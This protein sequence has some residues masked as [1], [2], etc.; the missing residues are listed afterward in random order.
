M[1]SYLQAI[2]GLGLFLL[3]MITMTDAL[4][5]LAGNSIRNVL[6]RFTRS[7]Y[8]GALTGAA[9]TALLQSSSATTVAAV[10]FVGA[11]LMSFSSALGIIFG[12]NLGTTI[13]GWVVALLGFKLNLGSVVLPLILLGAI[14]RLCF[15]GKAR[16]VGMA[17][18]GFGLIFVGIE[19]MQDGMSG[20][21]D[22]LNILNLPTDTWWGRL[23]LL[24]L[25]VVFT[26]ITQSSSAGVAATLT[27]LATDSI[28][29]SQGLAL[30]I[31]MDIG[32]TVTA[33]MATLG[34][35]VG[36]RRT[37]F[38]HL[39]YNLLT[40]V[41]AF[42]LL[43]GYVKFCETF[44]SEQL[45]RNPEFV[46]VAF[47]SGFNLLGVSLIL[48]FTAQFTRLMERIIP[49]I[50]S[51]YVSSLDNSLLKE[52]AMAVNAAR[53]SLVGEF[54]ALLLNCRSLLINGQPLKGI[55]LAELQ[56]AL[57]ESHHYVDS[58]P[59]ES[60]GK[61]QAGLMNLLHSLDHLQRFHER[62]D[63]DQARADHA[64]TEHLLAD[65]RERMIA[66]VE[67]ILQRIT[68]GNW[69]DAANTA[70]TTSQRMESTTDSYRN[71][72]I[73]RIASGD[74]D[75]PEATASLEAFR[76]MRRVSFHIAEITKRLAKV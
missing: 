13:T 3:G 8:S 56:V 58:I 41:L 33:V 49:D 66:D 16:S 37:G 35:S 65:E 7:P 75:V 1:I 21:R 24:L 59:L 36:S 73:A 54:N 64:R 15:G 40:G 17:M 69:D 25:G 52:P 45:S 19:Q 39:I 44:F 26:I 74:I 14:L 23:Q 68:L 43:T 18:A 57:D 47:H 67:E 50:Q 60:G 61:E 5:S 34:G 72:I 42:L 76:W 20:A 30:V 12:A 53:Q 63:E 55:D 9:S 29:L 28:T 11:G 27:A 48:P 32:T 71:A 51:T 70:G 22:L 2:G 31:G 4:R 38:S 6:M 10:G 46:L 62:C